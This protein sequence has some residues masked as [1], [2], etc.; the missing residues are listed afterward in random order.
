MYIKYTHKNG[1]CQEKKRIFIVKSWNLLQNSQFTC[2]LYIIC[3]GALLKL[4]CR[5]AVSGCSD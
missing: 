5:K 2:I 1:V 3:I 4:R